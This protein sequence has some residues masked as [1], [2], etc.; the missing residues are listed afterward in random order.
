MAV[1]R[2]YEHLQVEQP[3]A[4]ILRV[5]LNRPDRRNAM[6]AAMRAELEQLRGELGRDAGGTRVLILT[7]AGSAFSVGEDIAEM[8]QLAMET[9]R[10]F[11]AVSRGI[12]SFFDGIEELELPVIAAL[13]GVAAG[14][15][16]ELALSCDIRLASSAA[17][18][19]LPETNIGLIPGSGGCSR[20]VKLVGLAEAK[21]LLML[22]EVLPAEEAL[23]R[24]LVHEV[25]PAERFEEAVLD[26]ARRI[27][28]KA[29]LA[30]G[31]VKLVLNRCAD[32]DMA[33]ARDIE[34]LGQST[35][36]QTADHLEGVRAFL[37]KRAPE[38]Q[39][40]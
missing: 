30:V 19:A 14:G 3:E 18:F 9:T 4:G 2:T 36:R 17:R 8:E 7:G 12:H 40:R 37:A 38:W 39:G 11:R 29:P 13:N 20:L 24:G 15:G 22:A 23:R 27:A 16:A 6:N 26:Y 1:S 10:D 34:R 28:S 35:L 31:M 21:R 33:T 25:F 5:R 32:V